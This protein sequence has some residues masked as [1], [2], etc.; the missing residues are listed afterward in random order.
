MYQ[1]W[2]YPV[3]PTRMNEFG[4]SGEQPVVTPLKTETEE[5]REGDDSSAQPDTEHESDLSLT[6]QSLNTEING[7][8]TLVSE[9]AV[10]DKSVLDK[11]ND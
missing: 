8:N 4:G 6:G 2:I 1:R 11:K 10:S 9:D 7:S 5:V 3:D